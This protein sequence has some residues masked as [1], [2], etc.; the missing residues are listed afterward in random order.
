MPTS[1]QRGASLRLL[2]F[3][4]MLWLASFL[5]IFA[6]PTFFFEQISLAAEL[7]YRDLWERTPGA[8]DPWSWDLE[9][10]VPM[11]LALVVPSLVHRVLARRVG[12]PF[13]LQQ[14]R[15][16]VADYRSPRP[17]VV[18]TS[19]PIVRR[20]VGLYAGRLGT[21]MALSILPFDVLMSTHFWLNFGCLHYSYVR[22]V[23]EHLAFAVMLFGVAAY[24]VP[25][26]SRVVGR[27]P[28]IE[29]CRGPRPGG[30]G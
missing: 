1:A 10:C 11:A 20:L 6:R 8:G 12:S 5:V 17:W 4:W 16:V 30:H 15:A 24:H 9:L 27:R 3:T 26:T 29:T 28:S 23:P 18:T 7:K 14:G 21:A 25:T 2:R 22:S 19:Q 13:V